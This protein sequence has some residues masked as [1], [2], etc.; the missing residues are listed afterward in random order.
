MVHAG[1]NQASE[2][3]IAAS[4]LALMTVVMLD[5]AIMELVF[6]TLSILELTAKPTKRTFTFQ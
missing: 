6:A 2:D 3:L 5:G 4:E 1:V